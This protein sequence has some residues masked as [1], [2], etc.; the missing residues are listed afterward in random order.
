MKSGKLIF[1]I[2]VLV[3]FVAILAVAQSVPQ[4]INYQG[5]LTDSSGQPLSDGSTVDLTFAFYGVDSGS[6]PLYLT[7]LQ[8]NVVVTGGLYNVLIG[9]G[10]ITPGVESTL[11]EVFQKHQDVWMGVKVNTDPEMTPRSRITSSPYA[12]AVDIQ[13]FKNLDLDGDGHYKPISSNSP[14]DDCND[15]NA[16]IY[17]GAPE[18][19]DGIDNN[20]VDGIDEDEV[21]EFT[22]TNLKQA[23]ISQLGLSGNT[24]LNNDF[25]GVAWLDFSWSSITE[26]GGLEYAVDLTDLHLDSNLISD[27]SALSGLTNLSWLNL[28]FN[29]ISDISA[30]SGLNN[31]SYLGLNGNQIS[32]LQPLVDN[33]GLGSGDEVYVEFNPLDTEACTVEI[34][35]LEARGVNVWHTC[36]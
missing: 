28:G 5:R 8:G 19:C 27:I 23:V 15:D 1:V 32:D 6:T 20:C 7:V 34:P 31:L 25:C 22:D 16:S 11:A 33:I 26:L 10:T 12:M 30:L 29:P 24:V 9:S 14:N 36:P 21:V 13:W 2:S 17:P 3:G 35:A 4:L 18:F